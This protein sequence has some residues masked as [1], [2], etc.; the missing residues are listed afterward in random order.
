MQPEKRERIVRK[1]YRKA[2]GILSGGDGYGNLVLK[3][4]RVADHLSRA[5]ENTERCE[6]RRTYAQHRFE[7]IE[8]ALISIAEER[9]G[10]PQE[11]TIQNEIDQLL[12][13]P[14]GKAWTESETTSGFRESPKWSSVLLSDSELETTEDGSW[15]VSPSELRIHY[16]PEKVDAKVETA[17]LHPS[18]TEGFSGDET[19]G[20]ALNS[21]HDRWTELDTSYQQAYQQQKFL[22]FYL[23]V[24]RVVLNKFEE[25]T[26]VEMDRMESL[27]T[28]DQPLPDIFDGRPTLLQHAENIVHKYRGDVTS[29]PERMGR[30]KAWIGPGGEMAVMQLQRAIRQAGISDKYQNGN[31][32]SFCGLIERLVDRHFASPGS[33]TF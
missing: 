1:Y 2:L 17:V 5:K 24:L 26:P 31:P 12:E 21:I 32:E 8:E 18:D 11:K 6:Q 22:H 20:H 33:E 28:S 29:L 3:E 27:S 16:R 9:A 23:S 13:E 7:G 4:D 14:L 25:D 19:W 15:Q 30:F 10:D